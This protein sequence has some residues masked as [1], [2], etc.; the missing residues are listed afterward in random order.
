MG[1]LSED[2]REKPRNRH[3]EIFPRGPS[4][5]MN[6]Y[7]DRWNYDVGKVEKN[8]CRRFLSDYK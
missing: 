1:D 8:N 3:K 6:I 4:C 2:T 7:H 5:R